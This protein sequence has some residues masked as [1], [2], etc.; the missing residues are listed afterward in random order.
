MKNALTSTITILLLSLA[1]SLHAQ[2]PRKSTT[3]KSTKTIE[4]VD[5]NKLNQSITNPNLQKNLDAQQRLKESGTLFFKD[6][7]VGTPSQKQGEL[8]LSVVDKDFPAVNTTKVTLAGKS[9][10]Q[11]SICVTEN[12]DIAV[13]ARE[14]SY[15]SESP[16]S[17]IKPGQIFTAQSFISGQPATVV[18]PRNPITLAIDLRGVANTAFQVQHPEQNSQLLQAENILISQNATPPGANFSFSFHQIHS[19]DEME[20]KLT[21]QY[22]GALGSFSGKFGLNVGNKQEY[23]YYMLE[24]QQNMFSIQVDGMTA[25]NVFQQPGNDMSSYVYIDKVDYGR[26]GVI[27][28]KAT[29]TLEELGVNVSASYNGILNQASASAAYKQLNSKDEVKVLA[30]FYGG[31]S[32]AAI[33]SMENTVESGVPDLFTYIRAQPNNYRLAK[34]VGYT[35]KNMNNQSVGQNSKRTQT[36]E[37]CT[38]VP[39]AT[40]FKLKVTLT[41]IQCING[42]DGGGN[43]PDDY[44]IQ[45]YIVYKAL[46]K[47]KKFV[48]RDINKYL[49]LIDKEGQVP[50]IINPLIISDMSNQIHVRESGDIKERNR[51][52][53]SNSLV[54]NITLNELNDPNASFKIYTWLKEYTS[55]NYGLTT[56]NDDRV[57]INNEPISVKIKDVVEILLGLRDLN[58]QT[59]FHDQSIGKEVKFHNF[60]SGYMHL[61]NIQGITP[62]VLEGPIR[63]GSPGQKAAVWVQFE[64][65]K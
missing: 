30:R 64:L 43:D 14:F 46:A 40:I 33:Q 11:G 29:R 39:L 19:V 49:G 38:P 60:G 45:Q 61:A 58:A 22:R 27:V 65:I 47:D 2:I 54:F 12:L 23:Y 3:V 36:V 51:N 44:A 55:T 52:M 24:F 4:T 48:S 34:P 57:L 26:K 18:L 16:E 42:R 31:D 59:D 35:L 25:A 15:I 28:F 50:G 10:K 53:I 20:F 63:V 5:Q 7:K 13:N 41:D 32:P 6:L 1:M 9:T 8:V 17:W 21:G 37:T 62:M 56:R